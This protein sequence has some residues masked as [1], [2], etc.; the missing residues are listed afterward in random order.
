[1]SEFLSRLSAPERAVIAVSAAFAA[2][3]VVDP[4]VLLAARSL[5]AGTRGFFGDFTDLGKTGWMLGPL[6]A[7]IIALSLYRWYEYRWRAAAAAGLVSQLLAFLFAAVA[8]PSMA[9][10]LIKNILGRARPKLFDEIGPVAFQPFTFD[11]DYAAFPSGHATTIFALAAGLAVL[12]PRARVFLLVAAAWI[13]A[14]RFLIG[15]HYLSDT[16]AGAAVGWFGV[17][18]LRDRLAARR[19]V[20]EPSAAGAPL[21]RGR[22]LRSWLVGRARSAMPALPGGEEPE[23]AGMRHP[24][25]S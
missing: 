5:D 18:L 1:M 23:G 3:L 10:G 12:W 11:Y 17:H 19:L 4:L 16:I 15:S 7:G 8:V 25:N 22:R 14:T 21:L 6:G 24:S 2:F 20:F 9:A 13:A